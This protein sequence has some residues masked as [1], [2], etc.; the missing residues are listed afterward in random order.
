MVVVCCCCWESTFARFQIPHDNE[1]ND[2]EKDDD[3]VNTK[4]YNGT[5]SLVVKVLYRRGHNNDPSSP[6]T[7]VGTTHHRQLPFVVLDND[8]GD[9]KSDAIL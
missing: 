6:P 7:S 5:A 1:D 8:D 2:D 4:E 9:G 3:N